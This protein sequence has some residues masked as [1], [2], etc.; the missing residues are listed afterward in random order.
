MNKI[1]K[2]IWNE[3]LGA[4][5][6]V[7]E[8]TKVS[9]TGR[10]KSR[11]VIS[12][13]AFGTYMLLAFST[14]VNAAVY[15]VPA[16]ANIAPTINT[17]VNGDI[18]NLQGDAYL[19]DGVNTSAA[20]TLPSGLAINGNA[21]A[22]TGATPGVSTITIN[23][24]AGNYAQL[25]SPTGVI[26]NTS[27]VIFT[28]GNNSTTSGLTA[29][30]GVL[31]VS[32]TTTINGSGTLAFIAN[33]ASGGAGGAIYSSGSVSISSDTVGLINN[34]ALSNGAI[35]SGG[36]VTI[37]GSAITVTGNQA[38]GAFGA[39]Q[40]AA[41]GVY[42]G[43]ANSV[44][45][46]SDNHALGLVGVVGAGGGGAI[47]TGSTG[48]G[49]IVI[50]GNQITISGNSAKDQYGAIAASG[51][52]VTIGNSDGSTETVTITGN[53]AGSDYGAI[54]AYGG[55]VTI[56][57]NQIKVADNQAGGQIGAIV[58]FT[59]VSIGNAGITDTVEVTGNSAGTNIGAIASMGTVTISGN[60]ITVADNSTQGGYSAILAYGNVSIGNA[61]G[62]TSTVNVDNNSAGSGIGA[63]YSGGSVTINGSQIDVS[64]NSAGSS[65]G[66]IYAVG[67]VSIGDVGSTS[68]VTM[69]NNSAG[70]NGGAVYASS[71]V[72][73]VTGASSSISGNKAGGDGGAIWSSGNITIT[74][75]AGS[76]ATFADNGAGGTGGA[77]YIGSGKT[78]TATDTVFTGNIA[79]VNGGA[80]Y[81]GP[82]SFVNLSVTQDAT[83]SGNIATG[84]G[85][86]LYMD[87][88][89]TTNI[90]V[91]AGQT[92]TIGANTAD[93]A[94]SIVSLDA[95]STLNKLDA[96]TLILSAQ[97]SDVG[98]VDVQK[99]TL[100]LAQTGAFST[101]G[102]YT[103]ADGAT[104]SL[105]TAPATLNVGGAFTQAGNT[106]NLNV[107]LGS[108]M[109]G[110]P[111][112][113]PDITAASASLAGNLI[114]QGFDGATLPKTISTTGLDLIYN[115][116]HTTGSVS[117]GITGNFDSVSVSTNG[118]QQLPDYLVLGGGLA[119]NNNDYDIGY[120]LAWFS[121]STTY[122]GT[123]TVDPAA[124]P[125]FTVGVN[126]TDQTPTVAWDGKS[127][128]KNG[129]GT[130]ILAAV[131]SYDGTTTVNAG[132]L[133]TGT[134]DA[135]ADSS[136][137]TVAT[138][139]I[140]DL[141]NND[142]IINDLSGG[143]NVTL[144][145]AT[146]TENNTTATDSTTF[147]GIISGTGALT[148]TGAGTLTLTGANSYTGATTVSAGSLYVNGDQVAATG[149]TTVASGATLGGTGTIGGDVT[150][151]NGGTLDPGA[152]IG[153]VG[154]LTINGNLALNSGSVLKYQFGQA[155][156]PGGALNDLTVVN[157]NLTLGG[158]TLNVTVSP[159]G[160]FTP[161][162]YRVI[163]YTG[164]L[165]GSASDITMGTMPAGSQA[166]IQTSVLNQVNLINT[167]GMS[168]TFWDGNPISTGG[169]GVANDDIIQGGNGTWNANTSNNNWTNSDGSLN[170]AYANSSFAVF[171]GAP[172]IVTVDN[173]DGQVISGGM[174]FG[175]NGYV[176]QGD[177]LELASGTNFIQVGDGTTAGARYT[178]TIASELTGSGGIN[179]T[180]AGT[181]VLTGTNTYE[182][183]TTISGGT[184][185][186]G[187]GGTTGSV[188]GNITDNSALAFN[189]SDTSTFTGDIDGTGTVTQNGIGTTILTGQT[190]WTGGTAINAG[191]LTLDGSNGGAQLTGTITGQTGTTLNIDNGATWNLTGNSTVGNL[192]GNNGNI[193]INA[194]IAASTNDQITADTA[195]GNIA[196]AVSNTGG[197][198]HGKAPTLELINVTNPEASS[199]NYTLANGPLEVGLY[200]YNL[201]SGKQLN[202]SQANSANW[203]LA[204]S[205][206][207]ELITLVGASDQTSTWLMTNDSLLQRMGELRTSSSDE[208][209]HPYQTWIRGY[210]WQARVNTNN[211]QVGYIE[212]T[213]G[214]DLGAD[215][216]FDTSIG[217]IYG[218]LM[219]GYTNSRRS[220]NGGAG[221]SLTDTLYAGIYGTWINEKGYYID[222]LA[223]LG[224]IQNNIKAYDTENSRASYGTWGITASLEAGKQF[225]SQNGWYIEPQI[226]GTIINFTS[227]NFKTSGNAAN[228]EQRKA[229]S[230]DL[231]AGLVAGKN[232]KTERG[233]I[234]P[235]IKGM[236][237][238]SWTDCGGITYNG[239]TMIAN[240]SGDRYQV[241]GGIAWQIT[242]SSELHADYEY[243][244]GSRIEV[245]WKLNAGF[246]YNW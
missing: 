169:V 200:N 8:I 132:T 85:G 191:T 120:Q 246:R 89:V 14:P 15:S 104:T 197:E 158:N 76:L 77:I 228:I 60:S 116:I 20:I 82:N 155:G 17:S 175:T 119:N 193:G 194:N 211:S 181:L 88:G 232:I 227:S 95:T 192:N 67:N 130:L 205:Y 31:H 239:D 162:V 29:N 199:G 97:G 140:L 42:I 174:S 149:A 138:G 126:L 51:G 219:A 26:L 224:H 133:Q 32:G 78:L 66:A 165:T 129:A 123:F 63:I 90:D 131:N 207:K 218:G 59:S 167:A 220:M 55:P 11:I 121:G 178:A 115:V 242:N 48:G 159:D 61:D 215:K 71:D 56:N 64:K 214:A 166:T 198:I 186:L 10:N 1:F 139:A 188:V 73:F 100:A 212:N 94:D 206:G 68:A 25:Y 147:D 98:N 111:D 128:I 44:V 150:I 230:Y 236:Y 127:L 161:G 184:L 153:T 79:G 37:D 141:N 24:G 93:N 2:T 35:Y 21:S 80:I 151:A 164:T 99:G 58:S 83:D 244:K 109:I 210:G 39:I 41:G 9:K 75:A 216:T 190:L 145:T 171:Q 117:D 226:Q 182:G 40:A 234:Q 204:P 170:G 34:S 124:T 229:T 125:T 52:G 157:G 18:L 179:K 49:S 148:K 173:S 105:A 209:K 187:N 243:I 172:G 135:I 27:D 54:Y 241:G 86:F 91:A 134:T 114:V 160:S 30:G 72:T 118:A 231:R 45:T 223:K 185:Q 36:S 233:S 70:T 69:D 144:G 7:A 81:A 196:I 177:Q 195:N 4:W 43:N 208:Q 107:V 222:G 50:N 33:S 110:A 221:Q 201:L 168:F 103:T 16:G 136:A 146:L 142:Q 62:T 240:T 102:D 180:D 23:D 96:G 87:T 202:Y 57:G 238:R 245:P 47:Y 46:V 6:A 74:P 3:T 19:S 106:S 143:G 225:K 5:M 113:K 53:S 189:R 38:Q 13:L 163:N 101:I 65:G 217:K 12:A 183:G 22:T 176:I 152:A 213:Y 237:G 203:Y 108:G 235:Y 154:T 112:F 28:G 122:A 156:T 137:V 92:L 84:L